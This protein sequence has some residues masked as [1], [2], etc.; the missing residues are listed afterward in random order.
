MEEN[1]KT[2]LKVIAAVALLIFVVIFFLIFWPLGTIGA[3]ERGVRLRFGAVT[4]SVLDEGLYARIPVVEKIKK[5]DVKTQK[6]QVV[7]DAA[8]RDLQAVTT[9]IALNFHL[10]P[11]GVAKLYQSIGMDFMERIIAPAIQESVKACT[12]RFAA[13]ELI[14]KRPDVRDAIQILIVSKLSKDNIIV[15]A[16][17][18]VNFNFSK[19]FNEAIEAK[20]TAEQNALAAKNKLEQIK[21][22]AEQKIAEAKGKAE[23]MRI[24]AIAMQNSPQ[25]LELRALEKWNGILPQVTS[26]AVPFI[27]IK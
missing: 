10:K 15:D 27:N 20:V 25:I 9:T 17:N 1:E 2:G 22:E 16:L 21:F 8:S 26:G 6:Y 3:G 11:E 7:A 18:I 4:G 19:S 24:E 14:T 23:A 12:A 5:L 13:E